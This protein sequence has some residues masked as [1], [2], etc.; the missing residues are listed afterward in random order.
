MVNPPPPPGGRGAGQP[1]SSSPLFTESARAWMRG[2]RLALALVLDVMAGGTLG[3]VVIEGWSAWDAFYMTAITVATV[4][5]REI[6][7]LSRTGEAFTVLLMFG[8]VGTA[9]YT[10]TLLASMV[11]EGGLHRRFEQRRF[12][13]MLD[14]VSEHFILCGFGRIGSIIAEELHRQGVP[15]V[16]IERDPERVHSVLERGWLAVEAD[17]SQEEVLA[18]V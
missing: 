8:G 14:E 9:F 12:T 16:V 13:R 3:Y 2:L 1:K 7:P 18:R 4:G 10:V 5:Y 17:A 15:F 11:V 6:H